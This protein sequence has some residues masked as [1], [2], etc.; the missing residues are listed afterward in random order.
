MHRWISLSGNV[1]DRENIFRILE[2]ISFDQI[3]EV[4]NNNLKKSDNKE[5]EENLQK[6]ILQSIAFSFADRLFYYSERG[7]AI[8]NLSFLNTQESLKNEGICKSYPCSRW[9]I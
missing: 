3:L 1:M 6:T 4:Y 9:P 8:T 5:I 7:T 2:I